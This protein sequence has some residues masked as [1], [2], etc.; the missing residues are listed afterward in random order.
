MNKLRTKIELARWPVFEKIPLEWT[1]LLCFFDNL[2]IFDDD[3]PRYRLGRP[4][5]CL[6]RTPDQLW[7]HFLSKSLSSL[8]F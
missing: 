5:F 6:A 3:I 4:P 1:S 7:S 8:G 2:G